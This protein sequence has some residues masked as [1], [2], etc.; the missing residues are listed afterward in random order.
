VRLGETD[1]GVP[2]LDEAM[3]AVTTDETSPI[4][5]GIVYCAVIDTCLYMFDLR[6]AQEWTAALTRWTDSQPDL[7]PFR[8]QCLV[9]R[10]RL[11]ELHG[12]WTEAAGEARRACDLAS[13]P[14]NYFVAGS[15][16][17]QLAELYRLLGE[18]ERAEDAYRQAG[19]RGRSP[20]PGLAL[21]RL[22]QGQLDAAAAAVRRELGE[23]QGVLSRAALL[24]AYVEV[25]LKAEDVD[26]ARAGAE[27]LAAIATEHNAPYLR[28][29]AGHA[30]GTVLRANGDP[31]EALVPLRE[32]MAVWGEIDAP[33]LAAR[34]RVEIGLACQALGDGD[35]ARLELEAAVRTFHELG[36]K[37]YAEAAAEYW[38]SS[39]SSDV[40]TGVGRDAEYVAKHI[41]SRTSADRVSEPVPAIA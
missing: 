17:Y 29:V 7:V 15:D 11:F 5:T 39:V 37:R 23:A 13:L 33:Y 27:E 21:L 8:G 1:E 12:S 16:F 20:Q 24:P 28:G 19:E 32:A 34:T 18:F 31:K 22:A 30:L 40:I 38:N 35:S 26:A 25:M 9:H 41:A 14:V 4:V 10:A 2:W 3:L 6:R 36:A